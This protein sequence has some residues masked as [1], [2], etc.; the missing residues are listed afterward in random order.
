MAWRN[1]APLSLLLSA[2]LALRLPAPGRVVAVGD[3]HGDVHAYL[4]VLKLA[5]L[6]PS[7][8]SAQCVDE[9]KWIGG[10]A[11]LVQMG[12]V[13]DRGPDEAQ[14]M[15]VL[16]TLRQQAPASNGRVVCLLGNHEVMNVLGVAAP[17]VHPDSRTAFGRN[18]QAAFMA[19]GE[20]ARELSEWYVT[21]I[22]GDSCFVHA[23]LPA[24]ATADSLSALNRWTSEWL[25]G[26]RPVHDL[27]KNFVNGRKG[28]QLTAS[29]I[30]GRG[31]GIDT[32]PAYHCDAL[33]R[34]LRRLDCSRVVVGH[35]PQVMGINEA[36]DCLV[37]RCDT[38]MSKFVF[39][40]ACEALQIDSDGSVQVLQ[41]EEAIRRLE[42]EEEDDDEEDFGDGDER[43]R[44]ATANT[45][46]S[47]YDIYGMQ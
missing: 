11:T 7:D 42:E 12:D 31:L 46:E 30:W 21:C 19:G 20:L 40:G 14:C 23:N 32:P 44:V 36:C 8:S 43:W 9:I 29:P 34:T 41:E 35:T 4:R 45:A 2:A 26:E 6:V 28:P 17:F 15:A 37:W 22:V 1:A 18:R 16:R 27:P 24:D 13:L 10:D 33:R 47:W 39:S 38:G 25:R 5:R 3:V